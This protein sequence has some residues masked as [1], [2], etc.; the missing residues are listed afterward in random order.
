[1]L[2]KDAND[3]GISFLMAMP[4]KGSRK[5]TV[6]GESYRWIVTIEKVFRNADYGPKKI[7]VAI[8]SVAASGAKLLIVA[9]RH[10]QPGDWGTIE[11]EPVTPSDVSRWISMAIQK[12]WNPRVDGHTLRFDEAELFESL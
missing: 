3:R 6:E 11:V 7:N 1:M 9:E 5:L 2:R 4:K 8:E 12:G 10:S